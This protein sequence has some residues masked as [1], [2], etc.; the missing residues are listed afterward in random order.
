MQNKIDFVGTKNTYNEILFLVI[1]DEVSVVS[2]G[3]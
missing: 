3:M 2:V 1:F